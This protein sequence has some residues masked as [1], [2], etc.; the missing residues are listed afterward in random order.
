M[1]QANCETLSPT[2]LN[3]R[4]KELRQ[5]GIVE[6]GGDGYCLTARGRELFSYLQP[7]GKW[8][9]DWADGMGEGGEA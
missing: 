4:L 3:T 8:A 1:L 6:L 2:V 7:I 5:S 9:I